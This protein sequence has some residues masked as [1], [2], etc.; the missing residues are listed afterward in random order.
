M[1]GENA[2]YASI[3]TYAYPDSPR[4][5]RWEYSE[6]LVYKLPWLVSARYG[7]SVSSCNI[8]LTLLAD[9]PLGVRFG[10]LV[11]VFPA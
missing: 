4:K 1:N 3:K 9:S 7:N 6:Y 2:A 11:S 10:D 5:L 8:I